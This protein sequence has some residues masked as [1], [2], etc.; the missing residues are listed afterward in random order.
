MIGA[1]LGFFAPEIR[2]FGVPVLE[3]TI[4]LHRTV[5]TKFLP[6]AVKFYYAF[7]MR[8]LSRVFQVQCSSDPV[9]D[10]LFL[11]RR[12]RAIRTESHDHEYPTTP[13]TSTQT[14][15]TSRNVY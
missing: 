5:C 11:S 2:R 7:N 3:A 12:Y 4:S 13:T 14:A 9:F 15:R 6:T 1:H 8:D 10:R